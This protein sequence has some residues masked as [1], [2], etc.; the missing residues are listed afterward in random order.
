MNMKKS[1]TGLAV[2]LLLISC[3]E[4]FLG[5]DEVNNPER[6][7]ELLWNDLDRHY[8]LFTVRNLNWDS[9]YQVYRPQVTA[10]TT[11]TEL[12]TICAEMIEY[13]DDSHT[14]IRSA[15]YSL[16]H[17]SGYEQNLKAKYE[18]FSE[19]LVKDFYLEYTKYP[20]ANQNLYYGKVE[21]KD[22]GYIYLADMKRGANG[23]IIDNILAEIGHHQ[24]IIFDVRDNGGGS[25]TLPQ[26]I[27]GAFAD[28]SR[29]V[30]THQTRNGPSHNDFG[31]KFKLYVQPQ[32]A[33]N[34]SKPVIMLANRSTIS[35]GEH[36]ILYMRATP[37]V[38]LMGDT[39]AG[40]FGY[41]SNDRFLPNGWIYSYSIGRVLLPDGSS[42]D[43]IGHVPDIYVRNTLEDVYYDNNDVVMES[44]IQYLAEEYGIE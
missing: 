22:I 29:F 14:T 19:P 13:L 34:F 43:G 12:F 3:E 17:N 37:N 16:F 35:A 1:L 11:E 32:G 41:R 15:D 27:A 24:A 8:S 38:T 28:K 30:F 42:L 21:G 6:N 9:I 26:R 7:F 4:A 5:P 2:G 25:T 40:D 33:Q 31:E 18:E 23:G 10:R 44:A 39:T 36:F 20:D